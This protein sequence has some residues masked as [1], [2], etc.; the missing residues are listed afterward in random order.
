M[1]QFELVPMSEATLRLATGSSVTG[2]RAEIIRE[3]GGYIEQLGPKQAGKL[4]PDEGESVA[5]V[6]RR[7]GAAAKLANS[8]LVISRQGEE[9]FFWSARKRRGRPRGS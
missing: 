3:Y 4:T 8:D 6:R 9:V 7:I 5:T 2:K 1:P